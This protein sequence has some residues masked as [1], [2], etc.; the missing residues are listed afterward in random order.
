M[1][2]IFSILMSQGSVRIGKMAGIDIELHWLFI[3]LILFFI[4]YSLATAGTYLDTAVRLCP[5]P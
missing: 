2:N 4:S 1:E 5:D 3:L